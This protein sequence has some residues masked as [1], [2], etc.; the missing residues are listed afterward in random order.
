[1]LG[2]H[3]EHIARAWIARFASETTTGGSVT[4]A[5]HARVACR[6]H[7]FEHELDVVTLEG[8]EVTLIGEAKYTARA[9]TIGDLNRLEHIRPMVDRGGGTQVKL[10]LFAG[11]GGFRDDLVALAAGRD[12]VELV[13]LDRLY[14]GD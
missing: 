4:E 12:D 9:R 3:F 2:P 5:G 11:R 1:V 6:E 10:A 7:R 8:S 14:F 13:D